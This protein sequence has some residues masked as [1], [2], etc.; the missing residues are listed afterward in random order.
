MFAR[1]RGLRNRLI[2]RQKKQQELTLENSGLTRQQIGEDLL[3]RGYRR[4]SWF[5]QE[6]ADQ[7]SLGRVPQKLG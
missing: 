1:F 5:P 4:V 7:T 6:A 3:Q 2:S